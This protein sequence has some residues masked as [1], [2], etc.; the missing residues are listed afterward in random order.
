MGDHGKKLMDKCFCL[1]S[2]FIES[3]NQLCLRRTLFRL[4]EMSLSKRD[5]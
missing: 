1:K 5:K 3:I 2:Y 4:R